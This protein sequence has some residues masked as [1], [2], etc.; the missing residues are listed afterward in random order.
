MLIVINVE[1]RILTYAYCALIRLELGYGILNFEIWN[2][3]NHMLTKFEYQICQRMLLTLN[4]IKSP[5][6]TP[7]SINFANFNSYINFANNLVQFLLKHMLW[8]VVSVA[9]TIPMQTSL[10][11]CK[12]DHP[13]FMIPY[14]TYALNVLI[15]SELN[16]A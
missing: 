12:E 1:S 9:P 7:I 15:Q 13:Y 3:K 11:S 8:S 16:F 5:I 10:S 14:Q 2:M 4:S 6:W